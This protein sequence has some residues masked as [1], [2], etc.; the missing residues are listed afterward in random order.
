M[1]RINFEVLELK[2]RPLV[3]IIELQEIDEHFLV[4][5]H[6]GHKTADRL[7]TSLHI[8]TGDPFEA[9]KHMESLVE[10]K[11]EEGYRRV[12]NGANLVIP[13]FKTT[14][15]IQT[16]PRLQDEQEHRKLKIV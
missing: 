6:T 13:G 3:C 9:A 12:Q 7:L 4:V 11:H 8:S 14:G 10:Q 1:Q 15:Y 5:S 2:G 16:V